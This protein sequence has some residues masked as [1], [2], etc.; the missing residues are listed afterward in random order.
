MG[1]VVEPEKKRVF[2]SKKIELKERI[3]MQVLMKYGY[4]TV[5]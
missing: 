5:E 4:P 3:M 2:F 1:M